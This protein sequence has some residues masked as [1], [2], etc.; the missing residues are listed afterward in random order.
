M[1]NSPAAKAQEP[2]TAQVQSSVVHDAEDGMP[3]G[4]LAG[5]WHG[6]AADRRDMSSLGRRQEL[7][8]R[9]GFESV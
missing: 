8:V 9:A 1:S 2:G 5:K 6:T 7:R 3:M 4:H